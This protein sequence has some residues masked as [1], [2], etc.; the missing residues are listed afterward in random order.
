[1][2]RLLL[3][4]G[5]LF[6]NI[7]LLYKYSLKYVRVLINRY[8]LKIAAKRRLCKIIVGAGGV[9]QYGWVPT[10][11]EYMNILKKKDWEKYFYEHSIDAIL[12]EH[13]WEHLTK[14]EAMIAAKHCYRYLKKGGYLRVAV[15]DGFNLNKEYLDWVKPGGIG[16]GAKDHKVLYNYKTFKEIFESEGFKVE[17]LEYYDENGEFHYKEWPPDEGLI[18]RS[19]R[20]DKRNKGG[21]LKYTSLILDALKSI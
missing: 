12:A 7:M 16:D 14:E 11:I 5:I 13:V 1:M 21:E 2:F 8:K 19:K 10:D 3:K 9:C 15:P 6:E 20:Y 4:C 17:L 18:R